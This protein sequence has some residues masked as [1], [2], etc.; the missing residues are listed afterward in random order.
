MLIEQ[1]TPSQISSD[2][3]V[4]PGPAGLSGAVKVPTGS[5]N[6][7][8]GRGQG[9]SARASCPPACSSCVLIEGGILHSTGSGGGNGM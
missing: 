8:D 1:V 2:V 3:T 4:A 5:K 9:R 6:A 7:K